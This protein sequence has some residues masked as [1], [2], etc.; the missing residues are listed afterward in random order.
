MA[1]AGK[2]GQACAIIGQARA[3][4]GKDGRAWEGVGKRVMPH[5]ASYARL[6]RRFGVRMQK[7]R[8]C[9]HDLC[10]QDGLEGVEYFFPG[11]GGTVPYRRGA[12][13]KNMSL[14]TKKEKN[15]VLI[16]KIVFENKSVG[17]KCF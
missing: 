15:M 12:P 10:R 9:R 2:R 17:E 3:S 6:A 5:P 1:S 4:K 11:E 8:S 16:G 14:R 7:A 13:R